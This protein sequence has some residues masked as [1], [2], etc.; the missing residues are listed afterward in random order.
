MAV[1]AEPS[2]SRRRGATAVVSVGSVVSHDALELHER[3]GESRR[4]CVRH[5]VVPGD[6]EHRRPERPEKARRALVLVATS[7]VREVARMRRSAPARHGR[8][9]P[10]ARA[11]PP[12]PR[13]YP[14]GDRIHAGGAPT[15]PNEA[16]DSMNAMA[17]D[18]SEIFDDLY[19][20][21]RAGG[22]MRK[23]RRGEELTAEE[24]GGARAL[25]APVAC[26]QG[27]RD[28]RLR[29]RD[30]RARL[31]ARRPRVRPLAQGV[32][33]LAHALPGGVVP[34]LLRGAR[35]PDELGLEFVVKPVEA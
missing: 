25:A 27:D 17:D 30:V 28:R 34:V 18:S 12:G 21:L 10:R 6:R 22:A 24:A 13:V 16:I 35:D 7:A 26:P 23:Q 4:E 19:L 20:G 15:R 11:R 33:Q 2:S 31:H 1:R 14:C 32:A 8:S 3:A 9:A 29:A 5:V